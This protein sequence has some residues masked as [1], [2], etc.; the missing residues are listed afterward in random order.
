M[1]RTSPP[2]G[3]SNAGES[4]T[5][6]TPSGAPS[7]R[8]SVTVRTASTERQATSATAAARKWR[9]TGGATV[10]TG[11]ATRAAKVDRRRAQAS[12][13]LTWRSKSS[14]VSPRVTKR[15][16]S[17][18]EGCMSALLQRAAETGARIAE[19][20]TEALQGEP[21][22]G[23]EGVV[24][25]VGL[26]EHR[27]EHLALARRRGGEA[28]LDGLEELARFSL[29]LGGVGGDEGLC[30]FGGRVDAKRVGAAPV[31]DDEAG[32][33][34]DEAR[35]LEVVEAAVR[36]GLHDAEP[37]FLCDVAR[38]IEA[39]A[40]REEREDERVVV[41]GDGVFPEGVHP[42]A[43]NGRGARPYRVCRLTGVR[44][45]TEGARGR[46]A[47][48]GM[49]EQDSLRGARSPAEFIGQRV[50]FRGE[51]LEA[52][53]EARADGGAKRARALLGYHVRTGRLQLVR[54]G[55]YAHAGCCDGPLI[56][57]RL[58]EDAVVAFDAALLMRALVLETYRACFLTTQRVKPFTYSETEYRPVQI[59][60]AWWSTREVETVERGG[61]LVRVTS[62]ER[63]LVDCVE[64]L[65]LA[66]ELSQLVGAFRQATTL[67][68]DELLGIAEL[69]GS[70]L[71]MSR[72]AYCLQASGRLLSA[73]ELV[74][75]ETRGL[76]RPDYFSRAQRSGEDRIISRWN[77]IVT[78]EQHA[79]YERNRR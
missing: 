21:S 42:K 12:Q 39:E 66:P 23:G 41:A 56:A 76:Q 36:G 11:A 59:P 26:G 78:P 19:H 61:L 47:M 65:E 48:E 57:S 45:L 7:M 10:R 64:R 24:A 4:E 2:G 44:G 54:R 79:L 37:G 8:G 34:D 6:C 31:D 46:A 22:G 67:D 1:E 40:G 38:L 3:G 32:L 50:V 16:S 58:T 63:S 25:G 68:V 72:L 28:G 33:A 55:V 77:L 53:Y 5:P 62:L 30:F 15:W 60:R 29:M 18:T 43:E 20:L 71:L 14:E 69:R 73:A 74:R 27:E 17:K 52:W 51:E 9:S 49:E 13:V 35:E 70:R 75:L